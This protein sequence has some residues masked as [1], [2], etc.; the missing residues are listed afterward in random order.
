VEP[1]KTTFSAKEI[2][3]TGLSEPEAQD[4]MFM[5]YPTDDD[6]VFYGAQNFYSFIRFLYISY[7]R[8]LFATKST[9]TKQVKKDIDRLSEEWKDEEKVKKLKSIDFDSIVAEREYQCIRGLYSMNTQDQGKFED[10][11]QICGWSRCLFTYEKTLNLA[12]K[13]GAAIVGEES[14]MRAVRLFEEF[15]KKDEQLYFENYTKNPAVF[16]TQSVRV[17]FS[18]KTRVMSIHFFTFPKI[19]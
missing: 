19:L 1:K 10:I 14:N 9:I 13:H 5:P 18:P 3:T 11:F 2:R 4:S 6:V 7:E 12:G 17:L 15:S 16:N 8:L